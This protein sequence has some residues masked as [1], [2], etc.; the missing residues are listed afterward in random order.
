MNK[1]ILLLALTFIYITSVHAQI[2]I[3]IRAGLNAAYIPN[4]VGIKDF[5]FGKNIGFT[6]A[7]FSEFP[8]SEKLALQA[9]LSYSPKGYSIIFNDSLERGT[10]N[11]RAQF[12]YD[13]TSL[14]LSLKYRVNKLG[15][16]AGVEPSVLVNVN[17]KNRYGVKGAIDSQ[18]IQIDKFDFG[19]LAGIDYQIGPFLIDL[20][21][22]LGLATISDVT[23]T[24]ADGSIVVLINEKN[25]VI[26]ATVGYIF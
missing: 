3:G 19:V 7:V 18:F 16:L 14:A 20:R 4:V 17:Y 13:Y 23:F 10:A 1:K 15:L 8:I 9:N 21:Y 6:G 26:Q 25:R 2:K 22:I 11:I 5:S 12:N 24:D